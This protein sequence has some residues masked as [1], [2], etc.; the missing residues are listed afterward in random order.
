MSAGWYPR[1][2]SF[3]GGGARIPGSMG[4][5]AH[6]MDTGILEHVTDWYGSSAGCMCAL[7]GAIGVTGSW[8]K[9]AMDVFDGRL[10]SSIQE[11]YVCDF[12]KA[13]GLCSTKGLDEHL[14][15]LIDTWE[16]GCSSWTFADLAKNRPATNLHIAA[17]NLTQGSLF[18]FNAKN[19]PNIRL[20]DALCASSSLPLFFTPW[21][22]PTT[23]D[24]HCDGGILEN[25]P[26]S[27]IPNK[28][29]TLVVV[30]SDA[31]IV[32]RSTPAVTINTAAE[33]FGRIIALIHHHDAIVPKNWI[34]VN[35][36]TIHIIEFD[37]TQEEKTAAFE[38][39]IRSAKGWLAFR[40]SRTNLPGETAGNHPSSA[41]PNTSCAARPSPG[42]MSDSPQ[43][44]NPLLHS[45]PPPDSHSGT[46][47][48]ARR[49]SL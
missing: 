40:K 28:E 43:C 25:Y 45:D 9:D 41:D 44:H 32:G 21:I 38:E 1:A 7:M 20:L 23:G 29:D 3:G 36:K 48:C 42:R 12:A 10:V 34:A 37:L 5:L 11:D 30:C 18:I 39:G 4:V 16:P 15:R 31:D 8:I 47:R 13:W 33:Y 46:I 14:G 35:N 17:T 6:L 24:I 19:T 26:W 2:V 27:C 49:W 22:H